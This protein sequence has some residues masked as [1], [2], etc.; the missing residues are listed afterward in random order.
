M[1]LHWLDISNHFQVTF[2]QKISRNSMKRQPYCFLSKGWTCLGH[3]GTV[4]IKKT[5]HIQ[6][7]ME[8]NLLS[9][10]LPAG[11]NEMWCVMW[12]TVL[13]SV[14]AAVKQWIRDPIMLSTQTGRRRWEWILLCRGTEAT[15]APIN[16]LLFSSVSSGLT[17]NQSTNHTATPP[18]NRNKVRK[19]WQ[20]TFYR[21]VFIFLYFCQKN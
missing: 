3:V 16:L 17:L 20:Q 10:P 12:V 14:H 9:K 11:V 13:Q 18:N 19:W 2:F 1:E 7:Q 4:S 21:F 6:K 5:L 8:E 15:H